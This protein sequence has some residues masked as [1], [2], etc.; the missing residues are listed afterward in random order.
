MRAICL[1]LALCGCASSAP[2][3]FVVDSSFTW[4]EQGILQRAA[5]AWEAAGSP[6]IPYR[7][8]S[9]TNIMG[10]ALADPRGAVYAVRV[11]SN[12]DRDCPNRPRNIGWPETST[13]VASTDLGV[14][15]FN[16]SRIEG[17]Y[18]RTVAVH[19]IGHAWGLSHEKEGTASV[20]VPNPSLDTPTPID[21]EWMRYLHH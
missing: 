7:T 10:S 6:S 19:E 11:V 13:V 2:N 3:A 17:S 1:L 15:C 16:M 5:A 4:E 8:E 20:M 14:M 12:T 18:L 21:E 9:H